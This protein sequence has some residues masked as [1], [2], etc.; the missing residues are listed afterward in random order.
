MIYQKWNGSFLRVQR[1]SFRFIAVT[2]IY[3]IVTI[4]NNHVTEVGR[5]DSVGV[6]ICF[7]SVTKYCQIFKFKV[8]ALRN[9]NAVWLC[10]WN[11]FHKR[12]IVLCNK[13]FS[14]VCSNR[15]LVSIFICWKENTIK[16]WVQRG[17]LL[18]IIYIKLSLNRLNANHPYEQK[19][20]IKLNSFHGYF[21][22]N[23][24]DWFPYFTI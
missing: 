19:R 15:E 13:P 3:Y 1:S 23:L 18:M 4:E 9:F 6:C 21:L 24:N 11:C 12:N 20:D 5:E 8:C 10:S 16:D 7:L 14:L 2:D 22:L 17:L